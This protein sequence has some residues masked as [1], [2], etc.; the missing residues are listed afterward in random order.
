[1]AQQMIIQ[2]T[3]EQEEVAV[4]QDK[5][6]VEYY[7]ERQHEE[8]Q[9]GDIY[10]GVVEN[11]LPGMQA[12][13]IDIG[14]EKNAYLPLEEVLPPK[15]LNAAHP[16][17]QDILKV[18]QQIVVQVKKEAVDNKGPKVSCRLQLTGHGLIF[19]VDA[20]E[21]MV[22]HKITN[23]AKRK[24][25]QRAIA[26]TEGLGQ[27]GFIVRTA[28]ASL[29]LNALQAEAIALLQRWVLIEK[30]IHQATHKGLAAAEKSLGLQF[31]Q[32]LVR[33]G[34]VEEIITNSEEQAEQLKSCFP[35]LHRKGKIKCRPEQD[36]FEDY[37]L[38]QE[39]TSC[40]KR[41]VWLKNGGYLVLDKTEAL[42]V[43]DVNTGKFTGKGNFQQTI[44]Q[45]NLEAATEICRQIRL[46]NLSGIILVDFI[47]MD[48]EE[49]RQ[50]V[51]AI[52]EEAAAKDRIKCKVN[53][54]T[55][56]GLLELIRQRT[57]VP[58]NELLEKECPYCQGK[59]RIFSEETIGIKLKQELLELSKRTEAES[60]SVR[61][62]PYTAAYLIGNN[63]QHL[64]QLEMQIGKKLLV[65][66]LSSLADEEYHLRAI[67]MLEMQEG[68][69]LPVE[70]HEIL[71]VKI[72]AQH[73]EKKRD[74]IARLEGYVLN[75]LGGGSLI[76]QE[77]LV[78]CTQ[79]FATNAVCKLLS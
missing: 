75:I 5:R 42:N 52:M 63:G 4:I 76:G 28:A 65:E 41:K 57:R 53:G 48:E 61:C 24:E 54:W 3:A 36:L 62:H 38:K 40:S 8:P 56:A 69:K 30:K 6:L 78:E 32:N 77:V 13:F 70:P 18:G 51:L 11:I 1:M 68:N 14:W 27:H 46:R 49:G 22:S 25:L 31:A 17:L 45:M 15:E 74:G 64:Q 16:N 33:P 66:G 34:Q 7:L 55:G 43:I 19:L 12:A 10:R 73:H 47:S 67:H 9:I 20:K 72:T 39:I 58:L 26:C 29:P 21:I 2:V 79:V 37:G 60:I 59:G 23:E 50:K 71:R 35:Q 44:L